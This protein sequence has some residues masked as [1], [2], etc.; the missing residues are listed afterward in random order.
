MRVASLDIGIKRSKKANKRNADQALSKHRPC[1]F[2]V[3]MQQ[4]FSDKTHVVY[5]SAC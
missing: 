3:C 2:I 5:T 1:V 4:V